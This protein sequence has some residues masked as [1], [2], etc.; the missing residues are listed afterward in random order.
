MAQDNSGAAHGTVS[1][2]ATELNSALSAEPEEWV[3]FDCRFTLGEPRQGYDKY[4]ESHIP[5]AYYLDLEHDLS[6]PVQLHGGRHPLPYPDVLAE[7]LAAAGV[8]VNRHV[9]V[10][11]AGGGIA[12]RAWWLVRYLGHPDVRVLDG[13]WQAW[14]GAG[15]ATDAEVPPMRRGQ[16]EA[17]LRDELVAPVSEVEQISA[18]QRSGTLVDARAA[19]R[20][21]G[22]VEPLDKVAGH[23]PGAFNRPWL[24]GVS[25]EGTWKSSADQQQRFAHL[26]DRSGPLVVY[27][28]SG[29]TACANLFA[30][31]LAGIARAKLY[32]G[33]WSDWSSYPDHPV[34][35]GARTADEA[36]PK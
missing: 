20:F 6:S 4:L 1:I 28:G 34:E 32:P 9:V 23:I 24:E 18:G 16:F 19:N 5:G 22:D 31:E 7:K 14:T 12:P 3:V 8:D 33:S 17:T 13:G 2:S 30:L 36:L 35:Q 27:C 15:F 29:V 11:D 26:T 10:Y 25:P 21:R